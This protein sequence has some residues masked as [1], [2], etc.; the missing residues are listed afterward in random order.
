MSMNSV[1][2]PTFGVEHKDFQVWWMRFTAYAA[3]YDFSASVKK[4]RDPDLPSGKDTAINSST[5]E[6]KKQE[7]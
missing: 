7:K 3:V 1:Q 5:T 6:G 4:K 2:L